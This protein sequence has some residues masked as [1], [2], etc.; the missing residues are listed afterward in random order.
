MLLPADLLRR[1]SVGWYSYLSVV[2]WLTFGSAVQDR[3]SAKHPHPL[4]LVIGK[5][6]LRFVLIDECLQLNQRMRLLR[7]VYV[8]VEE[9][10]Q[11]VFGSDCHV[12]LLVGWLV[13]DY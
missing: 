10:A 6:R 9:A 13:T 2:G 7:L 12:Y 1:S 8:D 11:D 3:F 5:V 4:R